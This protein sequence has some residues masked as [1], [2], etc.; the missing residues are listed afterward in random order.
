MEALERAL[1]ALDRKIPPGKIPESD[2]PLVLKAREMQTKLESKKR[3]YWQEFHIPIF[4]IS[5]EISSLL[6]IFPL[7]LA[8]QYPQLK[9]QLQNALQKKD[10]D[11]IASALK[12]IDKRIPIES[13]P[14]KDKEM[15]NQAKAQIQNPDS[16][17]RD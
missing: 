17:S 6:K 8:D 14:A 15:I 7:F 3:T 13:I 9:S 2:K 1:D 12:A 5:L 11:E 16:K 4:A 10:A